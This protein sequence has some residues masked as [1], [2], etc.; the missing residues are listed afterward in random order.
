[1]QIYKENHIERKTWNVHF[2]FPLHNNRINLLTFGPPLTPAAFAVLKYIL[3]ES[4]KQEWDTLPKFY[5]KFK[6][7][8]V[9]YSKYVQLNTYQFLATSVLVANYF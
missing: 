4:T 5:E 1:M 8:I 6:K 2:D 7:G 3:M 9:R